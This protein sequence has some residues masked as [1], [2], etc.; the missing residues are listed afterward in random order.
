MSLLDPSGQG[1]APED[2]ERL[3]K[4]ELIAIPRETMPCRSRLIH[5]WTQ[6]HGDRIHKTCTDS[7]HTK[8]DHGKGGM[9]TKSYPN[10]EVICNWYLL[11]KGKSIFYNGKSLSISTTLQS[12]PYSIRSYPAH[13]DFF[14][15]VVLFSCVSY[16]WLCFALFCFCHI[17]VLV[18][19]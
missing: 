1:S 4:P 7:K 17:W 18:W 11:G 13:R 19:F 14:L 3:Y 10:Q 8:S 16:E 6:R 15:V 5:T 12:R 2:M 9:N